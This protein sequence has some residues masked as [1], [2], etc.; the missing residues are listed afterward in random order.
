M[1]AQA[2]KFMTLT[3]LLM[4]AALSGLLAGWVEVVLLGIQKL[5]SGK[6][7]LLGPRIIWMAAAANLALFIIVGLTLA[8]AK[9]FR[10]CSLSP[11]LTLT[12][13]AFLTLA[14]WL[15]IFPRIQWYASL[16]LAAGLAV[17]LGGWLSLRLN[18][19]PIRFAT[20]LAMAFLLATAVS[21]EIWL[22]WKEHQALSLL[23]APQANA[24]NVLLL[25]LDTVGARNMSLYGYKQPTTPRLEAFAKRGLLFESAIST[26]PWTAPSHASMFTGQYPHELSSDWDKPLDAKWPTLAETLSKHGYATAGVVA[27]TLVCGYES[28]LNRGFTHYDDYSPTVAELAVSSSLL[29]SVIHSAPLRKFIGTQEFITRRSADQINRHFLRWLDALPDQR[30]PFFAF[31]NYFDAH[32]PYLPPAPY[33]RKFGSP[34]ESRY[35]ARHDL[36]RSFRYDRDKMTAQENQAERS[37]YDG[38]IAYLDEQIGA[39]L[40]EL[41]RRGQ[42]QNTLVI[43]TADHG[44]TFGEHGHFTHGDNLYLPVLHVPLLMVYPKRFPAGVKISSPVSLRDLPATVLDLLELGQTQFPG[45]SLANLLCEDL[46]STVSP[47]LSEVN[48]APIKPG[49]YPLNSV[50]NMRSIILAPYQFIQNANGREELYDFLSDPAQQTDILECQELNHLIEELRCQVEEID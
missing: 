31:L 17:R 14:G 19:F 4:L 34:P 32:E 24:P 45:T 20:G 16:I 35:R 39:L 30:R 29:R 47:V 7:I 3:N 23:P 1:K 46:E 2:Q 38:A 28:G 5:A 37:A 25:V 40:D 13:F 41:Q 15:L 50:A 6:A 9:K 49:K 27:N 48:L 43:V 8:A 12:I 22:R 10:P 11:R 36:R 18:R 26:A 33:D 42:L 44:E 21:C